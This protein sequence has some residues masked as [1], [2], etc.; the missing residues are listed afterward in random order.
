MSA[1]RLAAGN[2]TTLKSSLG[3]KGKEREQRQIPGPYLIS[4]RAFT[5]QLQWLKKTKCS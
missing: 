5:V 4:G 2:D 1:L 3:K